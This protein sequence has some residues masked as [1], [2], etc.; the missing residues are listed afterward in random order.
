[1]DVLPILDLP[2]IVNNKSLKRNFAMTKDTKEALLIAS[3]LDIPQWEDR[4]ITP[5]FDSYGTIFGGDTHALLEVRVGHSF[6]A[7]GCADVEGTTLVSVPVGI[8]SSPVLPALLRKWI[9]ETLKGWT[10]IANYNVT[11]SSCPVNGW[12]VDGDPF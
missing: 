4:Y 3:L 6:D 5:L 8:A 9:S 11:G 12:A 2:V 10:Y 1:M 7:H